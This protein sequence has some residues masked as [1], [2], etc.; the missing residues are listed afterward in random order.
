LDFSR[1]TGAILTILGINH[2]LVKE[3]K[4]YSNTGQQP[5]LIGE[6]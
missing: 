2:P 6:I 3:I 5:S 1:N 4:V